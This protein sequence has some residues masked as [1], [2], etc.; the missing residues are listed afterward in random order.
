MA[1]PAVEIVGPAGVR[2]PDR[3]SLQAPPGPFPRDAAPAVGKAAPGGEPELGFWDFLD[4]INPLQHI[5]MI[6]TLYREITGDRISAP[7]RIAG[8]TLFFGPIGFAASLVNSLIEQVSGKDI[9]GTVLAMF[10]PG[11]ASPA[12][13]PPS[14]PSLP[15]PGRLAGSS[16]LSSDPPPLASAAPGAP[17]AGPA[18]MPAPGLLTRWPAPAALLAPGQPDRGASADGEDPPAGRPPRRPGRGDTGPWFATAML[19]GLDKYRA[20]ARERHAA[21]GALVD[22]LS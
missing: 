12:S 19:E 18:S 2:P 9:G 11:P 22:T 5:P 20:M 10:S 14:P 16:V 15:S 21:P 4:I 17:A 13:P 7:A 8:D 6:S 3:A 1:I